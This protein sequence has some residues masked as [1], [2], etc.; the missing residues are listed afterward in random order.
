MDM[1]LRDIITEEF[2]EQFQ[3]SFAHATGFGVVF[4]DLDGNHIGEGSNFTPYC[5]AINKTQEGAAYCAKTNRK[6]IEIAIETKKPSIYVCHAGLINIEVPIKYNGEYIG[7]FTAGQVLCSDMGSYPK[8]R[9]LGAIPW[10]ETE[11]ATEYFSKIKILTKQQ[12]E[13]TAVALEN[14][15]NY[16]IQ[17]IMYSKL[18]ESLIEEQNKRIEYEKNRIEIEHRLKLAELDALHKQ[19]TP[20]FIFN[21]IGSI[22]RLITL[23][24]YDLA[25]EIL[26]SFSKMLRYSLSNPS[27]KITLRQELDYIESYLNI[28]KIRFLGRIIY[29]INFDEDILNLEIPFFSLQPLIENAIEHGLLPLEGG[30]KLELNCLSK[31]DSYIIEV[32]DNGVGMTKE[33]LSYI[34][35]NLNEPKFIPT[36]NQIG[37]RNSY[38]RFNLL[39]E[40]RLSYTIE[41]NIGFGTS[42]SIKISKK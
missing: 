39:Y 14:I 27:V 18:Q 3:D 42:I 32:K 24:E 4:V 37:L 28:Q 25:K 34:Y 15:T 26:D 19:V 31:D 8:E 29:N 7:A 40:N 22:S 38:R 30:G 23:K 13:S 41:S 16:I 20:H 6:A 36:N 2:K 11:E 33:Q 5:A 35:D 12:I 1:D 10:L 9:K 17:S 21:V